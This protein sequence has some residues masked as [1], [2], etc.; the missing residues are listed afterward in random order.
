MIHRHRLALLG[1]AALALAAAGAAASAPTPATI[2]V[3]GDD[4][5]IIAER[6]QAASETNVA[7][8]G[9]GVRTV[10]GPTALGQ[11]IRAGAATA[12][13]VRTSFT[14]AFGPLAAVVERIGPDDQGRSFEGPGF[15]LFKV[16]HVS[17]TVAANQK[18]LRKGDEVLWYF[19]PNF[20]A[21]ELELTVPRA[22]VRR[23]KR[24]TV[25]VRAYDGEGNRAPAAGARVAYSGS[26]KTTSSAGRATF[27]ARRGVRSLR[28]A[29]SADIRSA[30]EP[31]CGYVGSRSECSPAKP[32]GGSLR[33]VVDGAT[34]AG[35][36][37]VAPALRSIA[38]NGVPAGSAAA[39]AWRGR[40]F[41]SPA[42]IQNAAR[43]LVSRYL[44]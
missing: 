7:D 27:R 18:I 23:G 34:R 11:L 19:T 5:T 22:P 14:E 15:W 30:S 39:L 6:R 25:T 4:A 38:Q 36:D 29:R 17:S 9:N 32:S 40:V 37:R 43:A 24:F 12:T 16:N 41:R 10:T 33:L 31:V 20:S 28:A 13:P 8:R 3:E 2:R 21:A 26:A 44:R 35:W 1:G 42:E